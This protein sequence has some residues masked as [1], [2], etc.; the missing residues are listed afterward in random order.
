M[1]ILLASI[2]LLATFSTI[3]QPKAHIGD[4]E[5]FKLV[6]DPK[7]ISF[8]GPTE[9]YIILT[10]IEHM[11]QY[12]TLVTANKNGSIKSVNDIVLNGGSYTNMFEIIS[13]QLAGDKLVAFIDNLNKTDGKHKLSYKYLSPGGVLGAEETTIGVFNYEKRGNAGNWYISSTPGGK[14]FAV[15]AQQPH[16]KDMAD[17]FNYYFL[18]ETLKPGKTGQFSFAENTKELPVS[19]FLASDNGDFYLLSYKNSYTA[20]NI[21]LNQ[22]SVN[23][24][25]GVITQVNIGEGLINTSYATTFSPEGNLLMAG[26]YKKK[27]KFG[28]DSESA[29]GTWLFNAA[30]PTEIKTIAYDKP[31]EYLTTKAIVAN[32]NTLYVVGEILKKVEEKNYATGM[33]ALDVNYIYNHGN[34]LVNAFDNDGNKK[35]EIP[36][37]RKW[38]TRNLEGPYQIAIGVMNNKLTLVYNDQ[39]GKYIDDRTY[40]NLLLPVLV[41]ITNDGLM[42]APVQYAKE[43]ETTKTDFMLYPMYNVGDNNHMVVLA[44]STEKIKGVAFK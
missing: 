39:Y 20:E 32:G 25:K 38:T 1:K 7:S 16:E 8:S 13:I 30:K 42:E 24:A 40:S 21:I 17:K 4:A 23:N 27:V 37:N 44:A 35:F 14:H 2:L 11:M 19:K 41:S 12:H 28:F 33:A 18:D 22:A 9:D 6:K 29:L 15:I 3:G 26:Y 43:M 36:L 34:I 10:R 5:D 31:I